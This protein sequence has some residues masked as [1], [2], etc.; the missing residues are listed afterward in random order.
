MQLVTLGIADIQMLQSR[1]GH[2]QLLALTRCNPRIFVVLLSSTV[3]SPSAI[4]FTR[5]FVALRW[6]IYYHRHDA[7]NAR[8][9][10]RATTEW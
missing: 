7:W 1:L 4:E 9:L 2:L 8:A 10:I 3:L 5:S 6:C